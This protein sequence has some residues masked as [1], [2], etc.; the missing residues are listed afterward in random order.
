[1]VGAIP[2]RRRGEDA[3]DEQLDTAHLDGLAHGVLLRI[4]ETRDDVLPDHGDLALARH[5]ELVQEAPP[6]HRERREALIRR[7][8]PCDGER[9]VLLAPPHEEPTPAP[10]DE[11]ARRDHLDLGDRRGADVGVGDL[12]LDPLAGR[13]PVPREARAHAPHVEAVRRDAG[14][15]LLHA[16]FEAVAEPDHHHQH[17]HPPEDAD[18]REHR[19][20]EVAAHRARDLAPLVEIDHSAL[21]ATDGLTRAAIRAGK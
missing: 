1:V 6:Q 19:A 5:V 13:Q 4:E 9:A 18:R 20:E 2:G 21:S 10:S 16:G 15:V 12:E 14:H 17:Q 3:D 7:D 11:H 8:V